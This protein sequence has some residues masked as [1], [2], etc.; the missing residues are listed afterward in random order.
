M[1]RK[2]TCS[3]YRKVPT[4]KHLGKFIYPT[5]ATQAENLF[6]RLGFMTFNVR[7]ENLTITP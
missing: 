2:K 1:I 4:I 5:V 3:K 7:L 6:P